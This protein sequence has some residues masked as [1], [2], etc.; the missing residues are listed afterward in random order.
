MRVR[1]L[2]GGLA[3]L[4]FAAVGCGG[5]GEGTAGAPDSASVVGEWTNTCERGTVKVLALRSD[6]TYTFQGG[7]QS[8]S[9]TVINSTY[10][11]AGDTM[12]FAQDDA[13]PGAGTYRWQRDD[14]RL[15][16]T[17]DDDGCWGRSA[18]LGGYVFTS[19]TPTTAALQR[20][21]EFAAVGLDYETAWEAHDP[22]AI[23]TLLADDGFVFSEHRDGSSPRSSASSSS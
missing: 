6:G 21:E 5:D 11:I 15:T 19:I 3:F 8:L 4:V 12:T 20:G 17:L 16:F 13:C 2:A 18:A 14:G 10:A 1:A 7:A 22:D 23:A 9:E